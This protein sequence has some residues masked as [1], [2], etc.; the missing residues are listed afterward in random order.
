MPLFDYVCGKCQARSEIL[1]RSD[2]SPA[3]PHC[4]AMK[5]VKQASAFAPL[6]STPGGGMPESCHS[7]SG[8][9]NGTCPNQ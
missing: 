3:C 2:E 9:K 4:G 8:L 6:A 1:V 7:C 5:L